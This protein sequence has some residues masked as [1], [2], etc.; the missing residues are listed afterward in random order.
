M[1]YYVT[2]EQLERLGIVHLLLAREIKGQVAQEYDHRVVVDT[3]EGKREVNLIRS[4]VE[5]I[6][7]ALKDWSE[8]IRVETPFIKI[9]NLG[10]PGRWTIRA[11]SEN[12]KNVTST[13]D[14]IV[15]DVGIKAKRDIKKDE[16]IYLPSDVF[17][18]GK[19]E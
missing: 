12:Y 10:K 14:V 16:Y 17:E 13:E 6:N 2:E 15:D 11:E 1:K 3:D 7:L 8:L 5:D 4:I 18:K 19:N 9:L